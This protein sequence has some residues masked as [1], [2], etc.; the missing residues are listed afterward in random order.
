MISISLFKDCK[1]YHV[2]SMEELMSLCAKLRSES[3]ER[4]HIYVDLEKDELIKLKFPY[5]NF[6]LT[7]NGKKLYNSIYAK[8]LDEKGEELTT[9]KTATLTITGSHNIFEN[10]IVT[11]ES[12]EPEIKGQE[13]ALSIYGDDNLFLKNEYWSTQD[14]LFVGPLP[15]ELN[16]R[17]LDFIPYDEDYQEGNLRNFFVDTKVAGT[18]DFIFGAGQAIFYHCDIVTGPDVRVETYVTAPANSLKDDFGYL[19]YECHLV[20]GGAKEGSTFLGRPWRDYGKSV[21]AYCEYDNHIN[22]VGFHDWSNIN[23][24]RT[25]RFEEYPLLEGRELVRNKL[26]STLPERYV[27]AVEEL[28][29][30]L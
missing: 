1:T 3:E 2:S 7:F 9:W 8:M 27:K 10:L 29:H 18:V 12:K 16:T 26:G 25:C 22:K 30:S 23:R 13:V 17:Y 6:Y 24:T 19:F 28:K 11:N 5:S 20:N 4:Y 14:T 15:D 21:F